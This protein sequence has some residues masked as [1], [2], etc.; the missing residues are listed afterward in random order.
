MIEKYFT[1]DNSNI[2]IDY[3]I[4]KFNCFADEYQEYKNKD[5][6][7]YLISMVDS[8]DLQI[9]KLNTV[10]SKQDMDVLYD[11]IKKESKDKVDGAIASNISSVMFNMNIFNSIFDMCKVDKKSSHL[12]K[13][14]IKSDS[15]KTLKRI[16]NNIFDIKLK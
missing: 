7:D 12:V 2:H 11:K 16:L 3:L 13:S 15:S 1:K 6:Y 5:K 9:K 14:I 10:L 4:Q 8:N